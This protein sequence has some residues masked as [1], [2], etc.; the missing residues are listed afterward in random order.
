M[1][2]TAKEVLL[3]ELLAGVKAVV[4]KVEEGW[5]REPAEASLAAELGMAAPWA[6]RAAVQAAVE[7]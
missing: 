2:A 7:L 6:A 3:V 1:V 4:A 5:E